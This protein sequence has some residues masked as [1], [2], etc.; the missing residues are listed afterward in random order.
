MESKEDQ[1]MSG[2]A[3]PGSC[4]C[5]AV[6]FSIRPPTLFCG[7]CHCSMCRRNHGAGYV[8]WFGVA[9]G[10]FAIDSGEANLVRFRSSDHGTRSFC[11]RCGSSLFCES[12]H[13]PDVVDVVLANMD[14]PIDLRPQFHFYFSDRVDWMPVNDGLPRLGGP[15]GREPLGGADA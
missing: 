6:R 1:A 14:A 9:R 13:H 11:G 12:T 15:T 10:Q 2:P 7:H 3:V 5:G 8:T 4:F